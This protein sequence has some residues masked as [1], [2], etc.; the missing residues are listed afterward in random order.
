MPTPFIHLTSMFHAMRL[1]QAA[2]P[3]LTLYLTPRFLKPWAATPGANQCGSHEKFRISKR[4]LN[5]KQKL[6]QNQ[7]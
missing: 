5:V 3:H 2:L 6:I 7:T 1:Q 4:F